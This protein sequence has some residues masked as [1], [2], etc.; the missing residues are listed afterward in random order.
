MNLINKW[1]NLYTRATILIVNNFLD[2]DDKPDEL[3]DD[4]IYVD[5]ISS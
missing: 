1:F 5:M 3:L 2:D 4:Y